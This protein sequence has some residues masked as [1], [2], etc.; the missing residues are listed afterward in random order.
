MHLFGLN[1]QLQDHETYGPFENGGGARDTT[2]N[3]FMAS[4]DNSERMTLKSPFI[5]HIEEFL[6]SS[7]FY[8][9][10]CPCCN[11]LYPLTGLVKA[12]IDFVPLL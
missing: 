1:W 10:Q 4:P 5:F 12:S 9:D 7:Q 6:E 8:I 3:T 2:P 11:F